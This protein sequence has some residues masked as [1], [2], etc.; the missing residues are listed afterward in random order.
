[1]GNLALLVAVGDPQGTER[2]APQDQDRGQA[3]QERVLERARQERETERDEK[4]RPEPQKKGEGV[5]RDEPQPDREKKRA[6]GE[7]KCAEGHLPEIHSRSGTTGSG[8]AQGPFHT[9]IF[10]VE[11]ASVT[12]DS[13]RSG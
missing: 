11:I 8:A 4:D 6:G 2:D 3:S 13:T 9:P 1:M 7:E 10:A 12:E 5:G